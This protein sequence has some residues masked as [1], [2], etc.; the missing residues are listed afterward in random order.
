MVRVKVIGSDVRASGANT[1]QSK[2]LKSV[3]TVD[4]LGLWEIRARDRRT[5]G[6]SCLGLWEIRARDRRATG[7]SKRL[8]SVETVDCL[9]LW[10]IRARG[11]PVEE[12]EISR[13]SRLFGALGNSSSRSSRDRPV[14][15]EVPKAFLDQSTG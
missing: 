13:N 6:Q 14:I 9:G 12:T 8:K 11:R 5:A 4:C 1:K 3:E 10:E 7:Q 2:R 15:L